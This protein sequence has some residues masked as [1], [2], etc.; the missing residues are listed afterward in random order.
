[1][2]RP[3]ATATSLATGPV[4][5]F[6]PSGPTSPTPTKA[7]LAPTTTASFPTLP[8]MVPPSV[9]TAE[10]LTLPRSVPPRTTTSPFTSPTA[11]SPG[12]T[13]VIPA[14]LSFALT[15]KSKIDSSSPAAPLATPS[16]ATS[17]A[18]AS[19]MSAAPAS[20]AS[21][22]TST[23]TSAAAAA[24]PVATVAASMATAMPAC[25]QEDTLGLVTQETMDWTPET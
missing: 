20:A 18:P 12:P 3:P 17:A 8:M 4:M 25:T 10:P 5:E 13:C 24:P 22:A 15:A 1:M 19:A 21:A 23:A 16:S 9:T 11:T 6:A 2:M 14:G 7:S